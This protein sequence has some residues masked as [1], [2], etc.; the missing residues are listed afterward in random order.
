MKRIILS[1]LA[2]LCAAASVS[3]QDAATE[4]RLNKLTGQLENIIEAQ[5]VQQRQIETLAKELDAL[6]DQMSKP[7]GN[8]ATH[9]DLKRLTDAIRDVDQKRMEDADKIAAQVARLAK[10]LTSAPPVRSNPSTTSGN[11]AP[12]SGKPEKGFSYVIQQ[13]DTISAIV[14]AYRDKNIKVTAEQIL[15]ANPGLKPERM[16]VGTKLWIPAP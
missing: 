8:Y 13:G 1:C 11:S 9:D 10:T 5:R 16:P 15:K 4:E 2:W 12:D 14:Q 6:R 7:T 3:A